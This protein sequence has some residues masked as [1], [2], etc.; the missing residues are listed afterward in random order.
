MIAGAKAAPNPKSKNQNRRS[1]TTDLTIL[2]KLKLAPGSTT[3]ELSCTRPQ[4][5]FATSIFE[6][7]N[8]GKEAICP[9]A[10]CQ[11]LDR[12]RG[13]YASTESSDRCCHATS[14]PGVAFRD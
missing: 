14:N 9:A 12:V 2:A 13:S 3:R 8:Q 6:E 7:Q 5:R 1:W 10:T 4:A 11:A